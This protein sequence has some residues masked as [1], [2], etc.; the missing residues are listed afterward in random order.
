[1]CCTLYSTDS[2]IGL[3]EAALVMIRH[4]KGEVR[5]VS[6]VESSRVGVDQQSIIMRQDRKRHKIR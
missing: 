1:M 4:H 5:G 3:E 2:F 6:R